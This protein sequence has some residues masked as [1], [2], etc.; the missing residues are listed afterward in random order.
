MT[1]LILSP[2]FEARSRIS[3]EVPGLPPSS[4]REDSKGGEED[5]RTADSSAFGFAV[6]DW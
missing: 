3:L 2:T 6:K 4:T 5:D 1:D